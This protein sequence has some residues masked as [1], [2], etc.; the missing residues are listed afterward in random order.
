M[1]KLFMC[2]VVII[3]FF[4]VGINAYSQF[5]SFNDIFPSVSTEIRTS[6]FSEN[7]HVSYNQ[8]ANGITL[9]AGTSSG[10]DP[11]ITNNVM[12]KNP[13]YV[14]ET[15][16]VIPINSSNLSMLDIYNALGNIRGLSGRL[17]ESHSR[18]QSTPLFEE[19]TRITSSTQ[20]SA[21]PDPAPA[22]RLPASEI[23]HIRLK[24]AN[25]GN[26][27]Y[28]AEIAPIQSGLRYS[29]T[30][31]RNMSYLFV[32]V[33]RQEQF[34]A[35]LYIEPIREGVLIYCIAGVDISDFAASRIHIES[36]IAKRLAVITGW[37]SDEI[38]KKVNNR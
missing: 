30:N 37:V 25:F 1:K 4:S 11:I 22:D 27:F 34:T 18:G 13:G 8:K 15:I 12:R 20:T 9:L 6:C 14:I 35:Q 38:T 3:I 29:L 2:V 17:Y 33:I 5:R 23:I 21:I 10:I 26:T 31:F 16:N 19:A 36:A 28:R 24:D 32:T 7:G